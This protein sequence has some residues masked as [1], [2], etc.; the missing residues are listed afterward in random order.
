MQFF[1]LLKIP[2]EIFRQVKN[3]ENIKSSELKR[4]YTTKSWPTSA[5]NLTKIMADSHINKNL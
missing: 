1:F 2:S 4:N 3:I 5:K